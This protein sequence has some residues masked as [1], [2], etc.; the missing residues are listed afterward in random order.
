MANKPTRERYSHAVA[1][2]HK[3]E[4]REQADERAVTRTKRTTKQQLARLDAGSYAAKRERARL[5][6]LK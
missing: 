6:K 4:K 3:A 2:Q 1:D 5:E